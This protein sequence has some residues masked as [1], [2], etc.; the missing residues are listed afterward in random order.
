MATLGRRLEGAG[1]KDIWVRASQAASTP[2]VEAWRQGCGGVTASVKSG[3]Q[4]KGRHKGRG[5]GMSSERKLGSL[6]ASHTAK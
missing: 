1:P 3:Q 2:S 5:R 4:E 6:E